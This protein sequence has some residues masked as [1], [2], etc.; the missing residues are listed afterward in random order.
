MKFN[1]QPTKKYKTDWCFRGIEI[2]WRDSDFDTYLPEEMPEVEGGEVTGFQLEKNMTFKEM[3]TKYLSTD[4]IHP[5]H[6]FSLT[7]IES[8]LREN[9]EGKNA[10]LLTN[11][12]SNLFPVADSEGTLFFVYAARRSDGWHV[13]V[14][15]F[16]NASQWFAGD[17]VF[18]RNVDLSDTSTLE[19][20]LSALEAFKAKLERIFN[21]E[22]LE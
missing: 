10:N 13:L 2:A 8:V 19:D 21:L 4:S 16:V 15:R 20:R 17:R 3:S 22:N 12:Y 18:F 5:Q 9:D 14:N 1:I 6:V 11:G 7:Q